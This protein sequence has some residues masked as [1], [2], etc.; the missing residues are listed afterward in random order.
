MIERSLIPVRARMDNPA[1]ARMDNPA[2]ARMDNPAKV[3][4]DNPV[5]V[6]MDNPAKARMGNPVRVRMDNPAKARMDNPAK[7]RMEGGGNLDLRKEATLKSV[8]ELLGLSLCEMQKGTRKLPKNDSLKEK[9]NWLKGQKNRRSKIFKKL[10]SSFSRS[11]TA[12]PASPRKML[13]SLPSSSTIQLVMRASWQRTWCNL[14]PAN[15]KN[16]GNKRTH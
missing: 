5:R 11:V 7:V 14:L 9:E 2:K 13:V 12:L 16:P 4:M 1:K 6:M 8:P 10:L 3:R 15:P